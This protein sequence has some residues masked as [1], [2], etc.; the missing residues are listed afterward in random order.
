V[1][2]S[3]ALGVDAV[4]N[5]IVGRAKALWPNATAERRASG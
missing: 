2:N 5:T 1:L 4:V 3:A